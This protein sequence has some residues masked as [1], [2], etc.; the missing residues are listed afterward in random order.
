MWFLVY[1]GRSCCG[2]VQTQSKRR[3]V[4]GLL[5]Q[6]KY[7][8]HILVACDLQNNE[9]FQQRILQIIADLFVTEADLESSVDVSLQFSDFN[10][11]NTAVNILRA[12]SLKM[13]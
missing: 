8:K 13:S 6:F 7:R 12:Y 2:A 10:S 5:V 1:F 4:K 11:C 3:N 9:E